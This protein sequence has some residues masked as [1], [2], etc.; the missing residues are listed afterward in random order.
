[1]SPLRSH[2]RVDTYYDSSGAKVKIPAYQNRSKMRHH[3]SA[4]LFFKLPDMQQVYSETSIAV[5][6]SHNLCNWQLVADIQTSKFS[7]LGLFELFRSRAILYSCALYI[8]QDSIVCVSRRP[9]FDTV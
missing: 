6:P 2:S 9:W 4:L 5:R 1:M 8:I 7:K 3:T